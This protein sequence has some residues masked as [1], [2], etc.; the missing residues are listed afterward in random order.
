MSLPPLPNL[1]VGLSTLPEP[2][3][4]SPNLSR[5][6]GWAS[7]PLPELWVGL[8][9]VCLGLTTRSGPPGRPPNPYRTYGW[10]T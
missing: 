7:Q 5:T 2:S 9:D 6:Y 1:R 3:G 4:G 8:P 10:A